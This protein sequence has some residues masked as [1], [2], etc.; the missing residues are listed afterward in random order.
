MSTATK[1]PVVKVGR[2]YRDG[3]GRSILIVGTT[4]HRDDWFV[5]ENGNWYTSDGLFLEWH[6]NIPGGQSSTTGR[7]SQFDLVRAA[8][9][10]WGDA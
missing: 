7:D 3:F 6:P 10:T 9:A 8:K 2:R 4:A 1:R 5:A